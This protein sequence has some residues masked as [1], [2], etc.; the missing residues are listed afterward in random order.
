MYTRKHLPSKPKSMGTNI[1][2]ILTFLLDQV[3][4]TEKLSALQSLV[5]IIHAVSALNMVD[6][7]VQYGVCNS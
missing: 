7:S 3:T 5:N 6:F 1:V 2:T 4:L